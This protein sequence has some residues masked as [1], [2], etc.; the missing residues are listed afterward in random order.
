[1]DRHRYIRVAFHGFK[2]LAS[3][4]RKHIYLDQEKVNRYHIC[5]SVERADLF[6]F[7][8]SPFPLCGAPDLV[9]IMSI[10][11]VTAS[12]LPSFTPSLD[13]STS[14]WTRCSPWWMRCFMLTWWISR[15]ATRSSFRG[16]YNRVQPLLCD[17]L[18][19]MT[20]G[21]SSD[22]RVQGQIHTAM[23]GVTHWC[24]CV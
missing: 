3:E 2:K 12:S 17:V 14:R 15:T 1:M 11:A 8:L 6:S 7:F 18:W 22:T 4:E 21:S 5:P 24:N 10:W 16:R 19:K 9:W 20:S 13:Q 23:I